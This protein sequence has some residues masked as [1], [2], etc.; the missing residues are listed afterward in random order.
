MIAEANPDFR[1]RRK[2]WTEQMGGTRLYFDREN[3]LHQQ[4]R[5]PCTF[6]Y[7]Q[8]TRKRSSRMRTTTPH[9][10]GGSLSGGGVSLTEIPLNMGP[11]TETPF[12]E[13]TW[14]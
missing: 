5:P 1:R 7:I 3:Q 9:H 14:D 6:V 12:S 4:N 13:G 10:T 2:A 11:G 8:Q